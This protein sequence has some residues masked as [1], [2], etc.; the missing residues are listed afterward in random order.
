MFQAEQDLASNAWLKLEE[1]FRALQQ[2]LDEQSDAWREDPDILT[3][4][5][6]RDADDKCKELYCLMCTVEFCNFW[7]RESEAKLPT[8]ALYSGAANDASLQRVMDLFVQ[9]AKRS[10]V[11]HSPCP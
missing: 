6:L 4:G 9:Y 8:R 5:L 1:S 7:Y 3:S 2:M 10:S 11:S